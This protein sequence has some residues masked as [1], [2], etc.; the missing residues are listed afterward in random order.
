MRFPAPLPDMTERA[1]QA[2]V[3]ELARMC[4]FL[5]IYHTHDSRR[6]ARGYPDL[7]LCGKNRYLLIECKSET[8]KLSDTQK[9]WLR[10][11]VEAG[12]ETYVVRPRHLQQLA[13]VLASPVRFDTALAIETE[14][15]ITG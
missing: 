14:K 4:G 6:S 13:D 8:G 2:Q 10:G 5:L 3:V 11:L 7:A 12:I 1:W 15:E 9:E